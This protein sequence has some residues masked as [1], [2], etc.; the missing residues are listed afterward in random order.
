MLSMKSND[1]NQSINISS[2]I[3]NTDYDNTSLPLKGVELNDSEENIDAAIKY[4]IIDKVQRFIVTIT[5][6]IFVVIM[7]MLLLILCPNDGMV[8][9]RDFDINKI[10]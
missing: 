1:F 9:M 7:R 5:H 3:L 4:G 2:E 6:N 8:D 10:K